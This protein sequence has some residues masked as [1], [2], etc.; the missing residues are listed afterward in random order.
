MLVPELQFLSPAAVR[1]A[2]SAASRNMG[3][4]VIW[5]CDIPGLSLREAA[6]VEVVFD[7]SAASSQRELCSSKNKVSP[8][9][10]HPHAVRELR[11]KGICSTFLRMERW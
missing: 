2:A 3:L 4:S 6:D 5:C 11:L 7:S 9:L 8:S 10:I 1:S